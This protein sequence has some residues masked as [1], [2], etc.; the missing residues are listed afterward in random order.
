MEDLTRIL[1]AS[2]PLYRKAD[3]TLDTTGEAVEQS[4]RKLR[5]A[6]QA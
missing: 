2:D 4:L 6:V 3:F 5:Q 1:E